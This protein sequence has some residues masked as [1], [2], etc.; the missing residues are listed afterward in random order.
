MNGTVVLSAGMGV[1]STAIVVRWLLEPGSR[2]FN[3]DNL[4][5]V[6]AMTGNEYHET[7]RLMQTHVLPLLADHHV[8]YVRKWVGSRKPSGSGTLQPGVGASVLVPTDATTS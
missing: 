5:L 6:T 3:L 1:E 7:A 2:D 4:I 8:R